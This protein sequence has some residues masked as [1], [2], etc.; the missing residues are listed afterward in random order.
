MTIGIV[1]LGL[2]GGSIGLAL[3][4]P[5][6]KIIGYDVNAESVKTAKDR[7]CIDTFA[8]LAEVAKADVVFVAVPPSHVIST[9]TELSALKD[10]HTVVTDCTSAKAEVNA[11]SLEAKDPH[12]VI[13]HPMA[14][15]E[16]SGA[17][18]ASAWM[19]RGAKWIVSPQKW[20]A[21]L[22][23]KSLED[24]IKAMGATPVRMEA[25]EHDRQIARVS[26][27][28]HAMAAL[29][30]LLQNGPRE[31][32]VAGGSWRDLTRVAGVDPDLWT[33]I[34]MANRTEISIALEEAQ[35]KLAVLKEDLDSGNAAGVRTFFEQARAAKL[36]SE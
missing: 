5:G 32:E 25:E 12:F 9:L 2:I 1:G 16:K 18:Y 20:T 36:R 34:F 11:W 24:L 21:T 19:F 10:P 4:E 26:H 3:R 28:P 35:S 31:V 29:L 8:V 22:A 7:F 23:T 13:A 14:G 30:V 33:Q 17:A 15:H 6:R 27:L